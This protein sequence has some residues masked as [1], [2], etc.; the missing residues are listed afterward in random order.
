M[1]RMLRFS[2]AFQ[3]YTLSR[4]LYTPRNL[5][6]DYT[7]YTAVGEDADVAGV[8]VQYS[9]IQGGFKRSRQ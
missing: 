2:R 7:A 8:F 4:Y 1:K 9:A 6:I 5:C 3:S